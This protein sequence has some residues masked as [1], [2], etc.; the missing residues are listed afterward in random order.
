M[1]QISNEDN[2]DSAYVNLNP[3][4]KFGRPLNCVAKNDE[5]IYVGAK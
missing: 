5:S 2:C 4:D 3:I 1:Q